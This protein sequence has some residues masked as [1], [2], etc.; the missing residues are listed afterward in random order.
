MGLFNPYPAKADCDYSTLFP[1]FYRPS[2][3]Q[4]ISSESGLRLSPQFDPTC[5]VS[6]Q[7]ISSES[8]LRRKVQGLGAALRQLFNPYPAKADC[9]MLQALLG[10]CCRSFQPISSESGLRLRQTECPCRSNPLFNPY[11]AKADCDYH[12]LLSA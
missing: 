4:P 8:G 7:P 6:F 11:P 9:D 5:K 10:R 12:L 3:F 2:S 1:C